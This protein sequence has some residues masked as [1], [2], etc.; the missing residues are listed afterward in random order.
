MLAAPMS[1]KCRALPLLALLLKVTA[2]GALFHDQR[3]ILVLTFVFAASCVALLPVNYAA[4]SVFLTPTFVLL[5]E[6]SAGDWN[7][8]ETRVLNT[9]LGGALALAG[10]RFLWPSP[11][12]ERFPA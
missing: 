9:L 3:A 8:A 5:A 2:L 6:A 11:E 12:R 7:L 10:A 1:R 4:F